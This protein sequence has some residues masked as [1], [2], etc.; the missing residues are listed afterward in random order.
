MAPS[1]EFPKAPPVTEKDFEDPNTQSLDFSDDDE[2]ANLIKYKLPIILPWHKAKTVRLGTTLHSSRL[3]SNNPWEENESPFLLDHLYR[4]PPKLTREYGTVASFKS[5]ETSKQCETR[6]HLS[7]GFG[8]G[9]GL[10]FLAT[11]SVKGHYDKDVQ[12]NTDSNKASIRSSIRAGTVEL[13]CQP[14]LTNQAIITVKYNGGVPALEERYGDYYVAG[15]K[16]GGDTAMLLSSSSYA[17]KEKE[18]YG[19]TLTVEV[20]FFEASK[21]WEKDFNTFASGSS[22]KLM[23]YDTLEGKNWNE[24]SS[25]RGEAA[26]RLFQKSK[27]IALSTQCMGERL[28]Q[29]LD[30]MGL[31]NGDEL[32]MEQCDALTK[33]GI[34]VELVLMPIR[35]LRHVMEWMVQDNII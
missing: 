34:V 30:E 33:K 28:S 5:V 10:P 16:L 8:V 3:S 24:A 13:E 23:G 21:H 1:K 2:L 27:E 15:Y 26:A 25:G 32:T 11:V 22:L 12:K 6:D 7:L 35:T 14:R 31:H 9:V 20:L 19:V 18:V 29:I 4:V 17:T